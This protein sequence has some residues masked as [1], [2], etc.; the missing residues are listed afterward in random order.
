LR[1]FDRQDWL[2]V[3]DPLRVHFVTAAGVA[4][5]QHTTRGDGSWELQRQTITVTAERRAGEVDPLVARAG[6]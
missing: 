5:A 6:G 3:H 1:W 4:L 2:R